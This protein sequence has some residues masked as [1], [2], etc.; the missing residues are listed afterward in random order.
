MKRILLV[1]LLLLS[2][3]FAFAQSPKPLSK[4]ETKEFVAQVKELVTVGDYE[5]AIKV[6]QENADLIVDKNI[7][8]VDREWWDSTKSDLERTNELFN[9]NDDAV[10]AAKRLF[11][12]QEFWKC[13]EAISALKLDRN[14][15]RLETIHQYNDLVSK[16]E[17]KQSI[18]KEVEHEM[19]GVI[20]LYNKKDVEQLFLTFFN[21]IKLVAEEDGGSIKGYVNP[22]YLPQLNSIL[23]EYG[24]LYKK[25]YDTYMETYANPL[26]KNNSF[27][28]VKDMGHNEAKDCLAFFKSLEALIK[29]GNDFPAAEF[30]FLAGKQ[31]EVLDYTAHAIPALEKRINETNPVNTYFKGGTLT[32]KQIKEDCAKVDESLGNILALDVNSY[33]HKHFSTALQAENYKESTEYKNN[34]REFQ[35]LRKQALNTVFYSIKDV[36]TGEYSLEHGCFFIEI[37][38]NK[39]VQPLF[40]GMKPSVSHSNEIE[41]VVHE[42]LT[43]AS[44]TNNWVVAGYRNGDKYYNYRLKLP[45]SKS[46]AANLEKKDCQMVVCFVPAGVKTYKCMGADYDGR[47]SYDIFYANKTCPYSVKCRILLF[48]KSG[49]LLVDK[50]IQ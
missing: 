13:S 36:N 16:M 46:V 35:E 21:G 44:F 42:S 50:I 5:T 4:K 28:K 2:V 10:K 9:N 27:P 1:G 38:S 22:E 34:L 18:L 33:Y 41:G 23:S 19:P 40:P 37:G 7:A 24:P 43:V 31:Q 14:N 17:G 30:P 26:E 45:V 48:S 25:Y 20:E 11:S 29:K 3:T 32:L 8:K 15:A 39:G 6:Y 12:N 47:G 49:E